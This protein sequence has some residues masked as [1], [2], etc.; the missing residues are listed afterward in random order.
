MADENDDVVVVT[1]DPE[2]AGDILPKD[3]EVRK[4]EGAADPLDDL[5]GQFANM[6]SKLQTTSQQL[7]V[8]EQERDEARRAAEVAQ[9]TVVETRKDSVEQGIAAAKTEGDAA[10]AEYVTAMEAGDLKAAARAQRRMSAAEASILR[11]TEAKGDLAA[12]KPVRTTPPERKPAP[13][14]TDPK[15]AYIS[16]FSPPS[17]AWLR[18]HPEYVTDTTKNASLI[19]AHHAALAAGQVEDTPE[20]FAEVE[21]TLGMR[22]G[23]AGGRRP[24]APAAPVGHSGGG[25]SGN[26]GNEVKLS[27]KEADAAVDGTHSWTYDD[28]TGK[29]RW[30]KGEPIGLQEFA[31]RKLIMQ[32]E[33]RY[34]RTLSE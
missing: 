33:G 13:A 25:M 17:Q 27:K 16:R 9:T 29:G 23:T 5:K 12:E 4:I 19:R 10:E 15:E 8:T 24:I 3:G 30:K 1:I 31:R 26:S 7:A 22:G 34:D 21:K 2:L 6:Q 28:P 20:Y 14:S 18:A 11:L 32:K